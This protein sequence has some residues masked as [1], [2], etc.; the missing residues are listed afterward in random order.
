MVDRFTV[1]Q[2]LAMGNDRLPRPDSCGKSL[3]A[4]G[5]VHVDY[6][7]PGHVFLVTVAQVPRV[8]LAW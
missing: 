8:H 5:V 7:D 4:E 3:L 2:L 6:G 1:T